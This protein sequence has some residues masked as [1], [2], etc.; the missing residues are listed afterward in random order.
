MKTKMFFRSL[1]ILSLISGL[2]SGCSD[3]KKDPVNEECDICEECKVCDTCEVCEEC[4]FSKDL[5]LPQVFFMTKLYY[6]QAALVMIK[7]QVIDPLVAYFEAEGSTVVSIFVDSD[8]RGSS[9]KNEFIFEVIISNNDGNEDPIY[10][11]FLT[12]KVDGVIPLW[13]M[14]TE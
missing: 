4:L 10:M 13:V 6:T 11:G 9:V 8:D 3:A 12:T 14:E 7:T 5:V 2:L 1:I